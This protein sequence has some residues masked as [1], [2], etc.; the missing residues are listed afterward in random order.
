MTKPTA[1][2]LAI[3]TLVTLGTLVLFGLASCGRQLSTS[4]IHKIV[5]EDWEKSRR[6]INTNLITYR[7]LYGEKPPRK[8]QD[9]IY[10][11]QDVNHK[12]IRDEIGATCASLPVLEI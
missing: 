12:T 4:E 5:C 7:L 11:D 9:I 3:T 6:T 1:Q 8:W 2:E 10:K